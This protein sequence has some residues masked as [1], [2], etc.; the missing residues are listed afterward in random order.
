MLGDEFYAL[1]QFQFHHPSEH[2]VNGERHC[3]VIHFVHSHP[4][5][6][7]TVVG[8]FITPGA[9]NVELAEIIAAAPA[10][11]GEKTSAR[12]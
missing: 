12:H 7:L 4:T 2:E 1:K 3:M 10:T 5:G 8:M 6:N 11:E 9:R